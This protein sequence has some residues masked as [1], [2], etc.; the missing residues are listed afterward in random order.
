MSASDPPTASRPVQIA[1]RWRKARSNGPMLEQR[2]DLPHAVYPTDR[3]LVEA[4]LVPPDALRT[5]GAWTVTITPVA[6]DGTPVPVVQ[7][8]VVDVSAERR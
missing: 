3:V 2:L 4:R 1:L 8:V 6:Q 5:S 7:P